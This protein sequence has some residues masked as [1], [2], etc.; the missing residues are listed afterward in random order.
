MRILSEPVAFDWDS[1]NID[2]NFKKHGVTSKEAEEVFTNKPLLVSQD[3]K[4]SLKESR[5]QA[6][7]ITSKKRLLFISFTI[8]KDKVRIISA[9]DMNKNEEVI[10]EKA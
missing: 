7:G 6:L 9:R 10:Y 2:K 5:F 8:R 4:H 3:F 1:G